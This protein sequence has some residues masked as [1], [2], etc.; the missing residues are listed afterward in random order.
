MSKQTDLQGRLAPVLLQSNVLLKS[1]QCRREGWNWCQPSTSCSFPPCCS[2]LCPRQAFYCFFPCPLPFSDINSLFLLFLIRNKEKQQGRCAVLPAAGLSAAS[3]HHAV[4]W[5]LPQLHFTLNPH[6]LP[7]A[8]I[9]MLQPRAS[10]LRG[11]HRACSSSFRQRES[12]CQRRGE[13]CSIRS[14][15]GRKSLHRDGL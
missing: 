6:P 14:I 5:P 7:S 13:P 12:S 1:P 4:G 8:A 11:E 9:G 10:L 15:K 2:S 3:Q